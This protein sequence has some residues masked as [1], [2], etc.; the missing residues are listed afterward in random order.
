MQYF[1]M[2]A[3]NAMLFQGLPPSLQQD[4]LSALLN[5]AILFIATVGGL[6]VTMCPFKKDNILPI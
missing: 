3:S 4:A 1:V 6:W 2:A 5:G